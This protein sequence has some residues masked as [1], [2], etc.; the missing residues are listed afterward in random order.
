VTV[1][2]DRRKRVFVRLLVELLVYGVLLLAYF[3]IVL[4]FLGKPLDRMFRENLP[5]YGVLGLG[6]I[7]AQAVLL[8]VVT[9]FLVGHLGLERLK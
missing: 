7:V 5:L 6:L 3:L 1:S 4:T 9:S 2:L 8:D